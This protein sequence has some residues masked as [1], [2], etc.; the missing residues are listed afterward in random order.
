MSFFDP[1]AYEAALAAIRDQARAD[2]YN[3]APSA[4]SV[5]RDPTVPAGH[6]PL[7]AA[8]QRAVMQAAGQLPAPKEQMSPGLAAAQLDQMS[9]GVEAMRNDGPGEAASRE[10]QA[11]QGGVTGMR[12]TTA[13]LA[14]TNPYDKPDD[15]S[16]QLTRMSGDVRGMRDAPATALFAQDE[17]NKETVGAPT[18]K[19]K[20]TG[21]VDELEELVQQL[22]TSRKRKDRGE[23]IAKKPE[24]EG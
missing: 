17:A 4:P 14:F 1:A 16:A 2:G 15:A 23:V 11:M 20:M 3:P 6:A 18:G 9:Q 24:P 12:N 13:P 19:P 7:S 8:H 10:L 5:R 22:K 21:S